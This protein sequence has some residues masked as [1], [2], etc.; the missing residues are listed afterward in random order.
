MSRTAA[1]RSILVLASFTPALAVPSSA[2]SAAPARSPTCGSV[3]TANVTLTRDI[4][5]CPVD[6]LVV[7]ASG[8]T[9]NL[10]GHTVTGTTSDGGGDP[11]SCSCGI[12]GRGGFDHVTVRGGR[13]EGFYDG[14]WFA[15]ANGVVVRDVTSRRHYENAIE[16]RNGRDAVVTGSTLADSYRGLKLVDARSVRVTDDTLAGNEHAGLATFRVIDSVVRGAN[17]PTRGGDY[18]LEI[19]N[20][21][22]NLLTANRVRDG[23]FDG[24]AVVDMP[25]E[26]ADAAVGNRVV[27]NDVRGGSTGIEILEIDGGPIKDTLV[28]GNTAS[29]TSDSGIIVG[30]ATSDGSGFPPF[31]YPTGIGP[32]KTTIRD[33]ATNDNAGDGIHLDAPGNLIAGNEANRNA[34]FGIFAVAGNTDGGGNRARRNGQPAQCSG[35]ACR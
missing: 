12:D 7:G 34:G 2:A 31:E 22:R 10:N 26:G 8:I 14:A 6:G 19:V 4:G 15:H 18:G 9:I 27:D 32:S 21:S 33:N 23:G 28:A 16:I 35:V 30:A 17:V 20:S 3:V 5:P 29:N 25:Q 1:V 24:I 11:D 13:I